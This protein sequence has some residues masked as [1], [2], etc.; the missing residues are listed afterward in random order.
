[1]HL[2]K[3]ALYPSGLSAL[4]AN[5]VRRYHYVKELKTWAEAQ[6]YCREKFTDLATVDNQDDN[7]RMQSVLEDSA[8]QAWI[9]LYDDTKL[10]NWALGNED[11]NIEFSPWA[12]NQPNNFQS[13]EACV[14]I[15]E[16]KAWGD[17]S[18]SRAYP[19][20]CYYGK[21]FTVQFQIA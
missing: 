9:G 18:C 13:K 2:L 8:V 6:S 7:D 16:N 15:K 1:M 4:S 21:I 10:W 19:A 17:I 11:F 20:V 14:V 3:T 5:N 12:P